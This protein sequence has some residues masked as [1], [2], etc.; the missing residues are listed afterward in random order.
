MHS[1]IHRLPAAACLMALLGC[2]SPG[3][4][5]NMANPDVLPSKGAAELWLRFLTAT[6]VGTVPVDAVPV[7]PLTRAG[8]DALDPAANHVIRLGHSSHL[9]K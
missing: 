7:L 2:S 4:Y 6:K 9:L 8:L 3:G 1:L 5:E